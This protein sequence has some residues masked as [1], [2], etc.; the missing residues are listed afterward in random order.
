MLQ[1]EYEEHPWTDHPSPETDM[2]LM[3][4]LPAIWDDDSHDA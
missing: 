2:V 4:G 1:R 3:A